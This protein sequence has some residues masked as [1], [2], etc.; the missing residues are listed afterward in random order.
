MMLINGKPGDSISAMD[1]GLQY[2]DGLFETIAL[3]QGKLLLWQRHMDRLR[4]GCKRLNIIMPDEGQ[5]RDEAIQL[6][7]H[8]NAGVLKL[9]VTR[10]VGG[11]GYI[12]PSVAGAGAEPTR[13]LVLYD[14][15]EDADEFSS[16]GISVRFCHT[17]LGEN[18]RLAGI[19]HLNRLEQVLA[20]NEW[21]DDQFQEGLML[22]HQGDVIEGTMSNVFIVFDNMLYTPCLES[23]GVEGVMRGLVME[24]AKPLSIEV[25][26]EDVS[27]QALMTADEVFVCNSIIGIWPVTRIQDKILDAGPVTRAMQKAVIEYHGE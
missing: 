13:I 15:P 12:A 10:G 2:G 3:Q 4:K 8:N 23:C 16:E 5:L 25:N 11:R 1:R 22:N 27:H 18:R 6:C 20:R 9:I 21:Q 17:R 14:W 24:L 7:D 26:E 19:K